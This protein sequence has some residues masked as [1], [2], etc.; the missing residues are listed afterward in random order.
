MIS[1]SR[2]KKVFLILTAFV[3]VIASV[4]MKAK[5]DYAPMT[6][7]KTPSLN[8]A[9]KQ[10]DIIIDNLSDENI[11]IKIN[12]TSHFSLKKDA[13]AGGTAAGAGQY[14]YNVGVTTDST[15]TY[16]NSI[17]FKEPFEV[18]FREAAHD[19]RGAAIDVTMHFNFV[20][21]IPAPT[22]TGTKLDGDFIFNMYTDVHDG[23]APCL[24][25][26]QGIG[27]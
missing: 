6:V 9:M 12:D 23:T 14:T 16:P 26:L 2:F 21:F 5:A 15:V 27:D 18:T 19:K 24:E 20:K 3:C 4:S 13:I 10:G 7:I 11:D 22:S 25:A 17:E 1:V 8:T